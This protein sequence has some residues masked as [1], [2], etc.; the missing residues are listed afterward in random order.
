MTPIPMTDEQGANLERFADMAV[1]YR[2]DAALRARVEN[3]DLEDELRELGVDP[4]PGVEM[5]IVADS[6]E[7]THFTFPPDPNAGLGDESLRGVAG[8]VDTAG[9]AATI[10]SASTLACSCAPSTLGS[11]GCVGTAGTSS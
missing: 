2:D 5:R 7:V 6:D 10:S 11:G 1:R 8:G 4:I 3:G 9:T